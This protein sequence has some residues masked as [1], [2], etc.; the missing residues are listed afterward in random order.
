MFNATPKIVTE[1]AKIKNILTTFEPHNQE[2][3]KTSQPD[4]LINCVLIKTKKCNLFKF[5]VVRVRVG[6]K[7]S[8]TVIVRARVSVYKTT[9]KS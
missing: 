9:T 8:D 5:V 1:D 2:M 4:V 3:L 7:A 6:N